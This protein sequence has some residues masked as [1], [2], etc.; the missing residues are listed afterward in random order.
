[1]GSKDG[2][3]G[4]TDFPFRAQ[5]SF[6]RTNFST[7]VFN[8]RPSNCPSTSR[9]YD[10]GMTIKHSR[11]LRLRNYGT[12]FT[13]N[14]ALI[15]DSEFRYKLKVG[16]EFLRIFP[17]PTVLNALTLLYGRPR[18]DNL[19]WLLKPRACSSDQLV[20][21]EVTQNRNSPRIASGTA[22]PRCCNRLG[23]ETGTVK[24]L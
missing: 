7:R 1:M 23:A 17:W 6:S 18:D 12:C 20:P 14:I 13:S 5:A 8:L 2:C 16:R 21:S 19:F 3:T 11:Q 4:L 22:F 24:V 9:A 15:K 10:T